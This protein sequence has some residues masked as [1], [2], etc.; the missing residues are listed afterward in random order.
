[1][2]VTFTWDNDEQT[3]LRFI[4]DEMW[5]VKD[6]QQAIDLSRQ[7]TNDNSD[8]IDVLIDMSEC[9]SMP[10][11]LSTLLTYL[12]SLDSQRVGVMVFITADLYLPKVMQLLNQILRRQF[13]MH[14]TNTLDD[15]RRIS[16]RATT[17]RQHSV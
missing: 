11:N 7:I 5:Q 6:L 16:D 1:M 10:S 3:R 2:S 9:N 12:Q 13:T 4:F 14:F 15:A 17:T 8:V